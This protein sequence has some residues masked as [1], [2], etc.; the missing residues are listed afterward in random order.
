M[1]KYLL[2]FF[3]KRYEGAKVYVSDADV[4]IKTPSTLGIIPN[5]RIVSVT[6]DY[7]FVHDTIDIYWISIKDGKIE[8]VP[9]GKKYVSGT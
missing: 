8:K 7:I 9:T 2:S 3:Q 6:N 4:H 1:K 5:A